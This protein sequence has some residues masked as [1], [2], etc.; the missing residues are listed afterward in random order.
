MVVR[1]VAVRF[2]NIGLASLPDP[3]TRITT[4]AVDIGM[5]ER[6]AATAAALHHGGR[7][8]YSSQD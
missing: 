1:N 5:P 6:R 2:S 4:S 3:I 7:H 8:K